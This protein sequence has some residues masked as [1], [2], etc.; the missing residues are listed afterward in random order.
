MI[1]ASLFPGRKLSSRARRS[2]GLSL[3]VLP[4]QI[5]VGRWNAGTAVIQIT[6]HSFESKPRSCMSCVRRSLPACSPLPCGRARTRRARAGPE[7]RLQISDSTLKSVFQVRT[8][9]FR[10]VNNVGTT[11]YH[12]TADCSRQQDRQ[13][14]PSNVGYPT[15]WH[16]LELT[17]SHRNRQQEK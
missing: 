9:P 17:T 7:R 12:Q 11:T 5:Q 13:S 4:M 3:P 2:P 1:S 10:V 14:L 6:V 15:F 16:E 8:V